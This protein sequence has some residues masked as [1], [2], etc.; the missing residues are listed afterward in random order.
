MTT[1]GLSVRSVDLRDDGLS[2]LQGRRGLLVAS[3]G[4][5]LAELLHMADL[6]G[7][8]EDSPVVTFDTP[9]ARSL[10]AERPH[11]FV[12]YVSPR[13]LPGTVRAARALATMDLHL[14]DFVLSTGASVAV[15]AWWAARRASVP[16]LYVE[17][18][19]RLVGPSLTGSI[20]ARLPQ[21]RL[22]TQHPGWA[23]HQW[24]PCRNVLG[25]F[26]PSAG[27]PSQP[28]PRRAMRLFVTLG[29]IKPYRFDRLVDQVLALT[30]PDDD[31]VWQVGSTGRDDLPGHTYNEMTSEM[32]DHAV[33]QADAVVAQ[34]GVGTLLRCLELGVM[35]VA[36]PR[37]G[38]FGEHVDDH[39]VQIATLLRERRLALTPDASRLSRLD[40]EVA[41]TGRRT[42]AV[43]D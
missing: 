43:P 5:H 18:F 27:G 41:A 16:F 28:A 4:G 11:G 33:E 29:T 3:S 36:V 2:P 13:D 37:L 7:L 8:R 23:D 34:A 6:I 24:E 35:P 12:P 17:S 9:Q 20:L 40:L 10:L 15:S 39:Q 32:F 22:F 42:I 30:T 31:I 21:A 25:A 38:R 1:T 26:V 14:V 19:A